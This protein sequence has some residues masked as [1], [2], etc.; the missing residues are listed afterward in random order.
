[1]GF[2]RQEYWNGLPFPSPGDLPDPGIEPGSPAFQVD[3]LT[4]EPPG[5]PQMGQRDPLLVP[6]CVVSPFKR[7]VLL[8]SVPPLIDNLLY[9]YPTHTNL[10]TP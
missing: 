4:S 9:L 2:S 7:A 3:A 1:M 5:K 6:H 10:L 8:L